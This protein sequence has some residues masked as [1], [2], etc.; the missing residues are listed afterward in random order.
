MSLLNL[1]D[2]TIDEQ[3]A[4]EKLLCV[5][6]KK[7]SQIAILIKTLLDTTDPMIEEVTGW[8]KA[9]DDHDNMSLQ[10]ALGQS[11]FSD[12]KL[13]FTKEQWLARIK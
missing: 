8:L 4:V 5:G 7:Y 10:S 3:R 13:Y 2:E 12:H 6:P 9:V 11:L 1:Y